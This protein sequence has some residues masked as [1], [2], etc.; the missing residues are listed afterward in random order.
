[1]T[2]FPPVAWTPEKAPALEGKY[3]ANSKLAAADRWEVG[4][5]GPEDVVVDEAGA[6]VAGLEDGRLV[7]FA[8]GKVPPRSWRTSVADRWVSSC[9]ATTSSCATPIWVYSSSPR[10]GP[11]RP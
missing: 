6:V 9:A 8:A 11:P 2:S 10:P 5:I 4:G 1:M 3:E 7:R